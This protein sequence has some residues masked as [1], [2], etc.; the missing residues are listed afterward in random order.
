MT[1]TVQNVFVITRVCYIGVLSHSFHYSWGD[2]NHSL[3]TTTPCWPRMQPW[4][5]REQEIVFIKIGIRYIWILL[6]CGILVFR[7][8]LE[9]AKWLEL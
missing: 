5:N 4:Y 9:K 3:C 1:V 8:T 6:Y 2:K 7:T